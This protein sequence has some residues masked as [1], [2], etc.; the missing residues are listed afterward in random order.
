MGMPVWW[1]L[2]TSD[3][4]FSQIHGKPRPSA[5]SVFADGDE[6]YMAI[7]NVCEMPAVT[8]PTGFT[9]EKIRDAAGFAAWATTANRI[10][11]SGYP[12]VHPIHHYG[13]CENGNMHCY[14]CYDGETIAAIASVLDNDGICS[15]EFVA[16]EAAYRRRGLAKAVCAAAVREAFAC[17]ARIITLR[18][19]GKGTGALYAA[20]GFTAY[21]HAL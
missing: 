3:A 9:V 10:M 21:N 20:L 11:F 19:I 5:S 17:G 8:L 1:D 2:Q 14:A 16:T 13:W 12:D 18:A 15:L 6:L 7:T 4:L